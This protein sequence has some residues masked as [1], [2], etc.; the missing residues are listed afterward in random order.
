MNNPTCIYASVSASMIMSGSKEK[1]T[2]DKEEVGD[3]VVIVESCGRTRRNETNRTRGGSDLAGGH[4]AQI[5]LLR[6]A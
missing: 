1:L 3:G 2:G 4:H 6:Q 5:D